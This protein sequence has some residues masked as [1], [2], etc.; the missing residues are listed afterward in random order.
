M[1]RASTRRNL[2]AFLAEKYKV[3]EAYVRLVVFRS[4][5]TSR[6]HSLMCVFFVEEDDTSAKVCITY[7]RREKPS[8]A[9]VFIT[10][11]F[12]FKGKFAEY[13]F[14]CFPLLIP[15]SDGVHTLYQPKKGRQLC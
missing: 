12:F 6:E 2:Y 10:I 3:T 11:A 1:R 15:F 7:T 9:P 14:F 5:L 8:N 13:A 4:K